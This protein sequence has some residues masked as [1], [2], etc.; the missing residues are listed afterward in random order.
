MSSRRKECDQGTLDQWFTHI[1]HLE[2][3]AKVIA[4]HVD[5]SHVFVDSSCGT[6]ELSLLLSKYDIK[7]LNYDIDI[8]NSVT[9]EITQ[10]DWLSIEFL[11]V[12]DFVMGFNPPFGHKGKLAKQ[13][14]EHG[15]H[16]G[17]SMICIISPPITGYHGRPWCPEGFVE[18]HRELVPDNAFIKNGTRVSAHANFIIFKKDEQGY[19]NNMEQWKEEDK[20]PLPEGWSIQKLGL[21]LQ[22]RGTLSYDKFPKNESHIIIRTTGKYAGQSAILW[23]QSSHYRLNHKSKLVKVS[24]DKTSN[25]DHHCVIG[26]SKRYSGQ[27]RIEFMSKLMPLFERMRRRAGNKIGINHYDIRHVIFQQHGLC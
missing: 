9:K 14:I 22:T 5:T 8:S 21:Y 23:S 20:R 19:R 2:H 10:K 3:Y 12:K 7:T 6:G 11:E 16:L 1:S 25:V 18:L 4:K 27:K 26:V 17:A 13:F 24:K 15:I